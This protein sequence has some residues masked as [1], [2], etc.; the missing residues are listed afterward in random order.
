VALNRAKW[1][2]TT[3][4]HNPDVFRLDRADLPDLLT[5]KKEQLSLFADVTPTTVVSGEL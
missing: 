4:D 5:P 2:V 1:F 3:A